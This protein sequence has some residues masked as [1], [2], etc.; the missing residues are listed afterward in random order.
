MEA[1]E[2]SSGGLSRSTRH[3][4]ASHGVRSRGA[5]LRESPPPPAEPRPTDGLCSP[6]GDVFSTRTSEQSD[7]TMLRL[8]YRTQRPP[9]TLTPT[10][11]R[12]LYNDTTVAYTTEQNQHS[13]FAL[14]FKLDDSHIA[15]KANREAIERRETQDEVSKGYEH[16]HPPCKPSAL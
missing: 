1:V 7:V 5:S 6:V 8:S 14:R 13:D 3:G 9:A 4:M 15:K 11:S 12:R 2:H 16:R 10:S